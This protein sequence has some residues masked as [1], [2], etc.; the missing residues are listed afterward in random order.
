VTYRPISMADVEAGA[1]SVIGVPIPDLKIYLLDQYGQPVPVGVPG[2]IY[3]GGAG[4]A[5][6]YLNRDELT[7]ARFVADPI[8]P[9]GGRVYRSG[10]LARW[11]PSGQ[12]EYLGRIDQQVKIRGFRIELGEIEATVQAH[13]DV[14]ECTVIVG[15]ERPE[16]QR[17]VAYVVPEVG[18]EVSS[19][20]LRSFLRER[21]PDYMVPAAFVAL[22]SLPLTPNGKIDRRALPS[23]G[24]GDRETYVEPRSEMERDLAELWASVLRVPRVGIHDNFFDLG[25]HSLLLTKLISIVRDRLGTEIPMRLLFEKPTIAELSAEICRNSPKTPPLPAITPISRANRDAG[26]M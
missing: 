17:L 25:G 11:L 15:D 12:L 10:D 8:D 26:K 14:R 9:T 21:L 24:T 3:V 13:P 18:T 23:P 1:G 5:R 19:L 20:E 16:D 6:G 2:E 22:P 4:V 7:A